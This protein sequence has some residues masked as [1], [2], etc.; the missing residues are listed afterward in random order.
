MLGM[1]HSCAGKGRYFSVSKSSSEFNR[2]CLVRFPGRTR[3]PDAEMASAY[4]HQCVTA[5]DPNPD[6]TAARPGPQGGL[7]Y[8]VEGLAVPSPQLDISR[9]GA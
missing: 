3:P 4:G 5:W 2:V 7:S 9:F 6:R 8:V 1:S